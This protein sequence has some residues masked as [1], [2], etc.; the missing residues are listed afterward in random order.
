MYMYMYIQLCM[1]LVDMYMYVCCACTYT[2][3]LDFGEEIRDNSVEEFQVLLQKLGD[4]GITNSPQYYQLLQTKNKVHV[5]VCTYIHMYTC[6]Y[7]CMHTV[8][9]YNVH[10]SLSVGCSL[11]ILP[12]AEITVFTARIPK[13]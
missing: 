12:A 13:S 1:V 9:M 3:L 11:L 2:Y 6:M 5:H 7:M 8:Y 10:T 4:I